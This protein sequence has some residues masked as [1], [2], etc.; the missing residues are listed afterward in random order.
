MSALDTL[1]NIVDNNIGNYLGMP[2]MIRNKKQ[3]YREYGS[4]TKKRNKTKEL[5]NKKI[6]ENSR[7]RNRKGK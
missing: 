7:K 1:K 5:K 2:P 3:K 4:T 6:A